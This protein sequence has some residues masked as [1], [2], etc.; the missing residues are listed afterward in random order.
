MAGKLPYLKETPSQTAGPYVHIGLAPATAG[1][2]LNGPQPGAEIAA[3]GVSGQR[4]R[5]EGT[6]LDAN[7]APVRD[8]VIEV[9]QTDAEGRYPHP[10]DPRRAEV[11]PGFHGWGRVIPDLATGRF[12]FE[13]VKPGPVPGPGGVPQ[14]PHLTLWLVARGINIGL[15]TRLYFADEEAANAACPVL[16]RIEAHRRPTLIATRGADGPPPVYRF[17]IHLAGP[18]ETVFFD[19]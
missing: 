17:D 13:T 7:G 19:I 3:S 2:C 6:V 16:A 11:E 12:A 14:A 5:I 4:I 18:A 10:D 15:H 1:L 9:W 8:A